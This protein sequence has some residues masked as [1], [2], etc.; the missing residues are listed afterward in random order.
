M[1]YT[2]YS[3]DSIPSSEPKSLADGLTIHFCEHARAS[4]LSKVPVGGSVSEIQ[5]YTSASMIRASVL[6][7]VPVGGS[8]SGIQQYTSASMLRASVL[9][10]MP[11]F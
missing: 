1:K 7:K 6:S 8:V 4:V 10:K 11:G 5:Q 3:G 9:W 2:K